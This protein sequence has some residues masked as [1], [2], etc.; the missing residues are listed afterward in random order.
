MTTKQLFSKFELLEQNLRKNQYLLDAVQSM[1]RRQNEITNLHSHSL[2]IEGLHE[3]HNAV[4]ATRNKLREIIQ[5]I[6]KLSPI[7]IL[8]EVENLLGS[9]AETESGLD[10]ETNAKLN[11]L[12]TE[13]ESFRGAYEKC[14]LAQQLGETAQLL[15][16]AQRVDVAI[17]S[18][19]MFATVVLK[20]LCSEAGMERTDGQLE[21]Y[22]SSETDF[23]LFLEK[24]N[25]LEQIY[26][27]FCHLFNVSAKQ[28]PLKIVKIESGTAWAWLKGSIVVV[29]AM[30]SVIEKAAHYFYRNYT[31][32][33]KLSTITKKV[34]TIESVLHLSDELKQ[35]NISTEQLDDHLKKASI[36]IGNQLEKLLSGEE[37]IELNGEV[38]ALT[39]SSQ[40]KLIAKKHV[41]LIEDKPAQ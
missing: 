30:R 22:L 21:I 11:T 23:L 4:N 26:E 10:A 9:L 33:G 15:S 13:L 34:E 28:E 29:T 12:K 35:R 36:T 37:E 32:E 38:I 7:R 18:S 1:S 40:Q 6:K 27:E 31:D 25:A 19:I 20:N 16:V 8:K 17:N 39:P 24:I 14:I 2:V 41:R 5:E 3:T